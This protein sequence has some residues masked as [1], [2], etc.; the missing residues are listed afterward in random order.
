MIDFAWESRFDEMYFCGLVPYCA[1]KILRK[2]VP[3]IPQ[4]LWSVSMLRS[5]SYIWDLRYVTAGEI[6]LNLPLSI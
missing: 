6:I 2:Y 4:S 1:S 3:D 5:Q